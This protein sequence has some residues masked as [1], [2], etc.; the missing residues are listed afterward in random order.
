MQN[1]VACNGMS[2]HV[3]KNI[4]CF[5]E[6]ECELRMNSI[7]MNGIWISAIWMNSIWMDV[8]WMNAVCLK[9]GEILW[10]FLLV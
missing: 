7:W 2:F 1:G 8:A 3:V 9:N 10:Y 4:W 6:L 5:L